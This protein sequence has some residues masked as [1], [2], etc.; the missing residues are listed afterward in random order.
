MLVYFPSTAVLQNAIE[1]WSSPCGTRGEDPSI[2]QQLE[3]VKRV[4]VEPMNATTDEFDARLN[5]YKQAAETANAPSQ[6]GTRTVSGA[7]LLAVLRGRSSEGLNFSHDHARAVVMVSIAYPPIHDIKVASKRTRPMGAEWYTGQA[8]KAANQAIG[9]LI[10]NTSDYGALVL[11]DRRFATPRM[12]ALLPSWVQQ[13]RRQW[14]ARTAQEVAP[15]LAAVSA[16]F[17]HKREVG[18]EVAQGYEPR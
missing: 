12:R 3:A 7:I 6:E 13:A 18:T 9:R 8:F 4:F 2:C 11:L 14:H 17:E 5:A 10:R 15:G 1:A 16:F